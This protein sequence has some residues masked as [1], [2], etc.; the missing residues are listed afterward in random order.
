MWL[1]CFFFVAKKRNMLCKY[2]LHIGALKVDTGSA[3]CMEVGG[4]IA[5]L[6]DLVV[7]FQRMDYGG[8]V[9]T[10]GSEIEFIDDAKEALIALWYESD[11]QSKAAFAVYVIN[12]RWVYEPLWECPLDFATFRYDDH[13]ATIGCVDTSAA[14]LI[15]ANRGTRYH[16]GAVGLSE[17]VKLDYDRITIGNSYKAQMMGTEVSGSDTYTLM[18]NDTNTDYYGLVLAL[19]RFEEQIGT[20]GSLVLNDEFNA[21]EFKQGSGTSGQYYFKAL[22]DCEVD[23]DF[24]QMKIWG[25]KN[26]KVYNYETR[27]YQTVSTSRLEL[28]YILRMFDE[29]D[30]VNTE[31]ILADSDLEKADGVHDYVYPC[32][33]KGKFHVPAGYSV[34]MF[35]YGKEYIEDDKPWIMR[36]PYTFGHDTV[37][38]LSTDKG[39]VKWDSRS[40]NVDMRVIKPVTLLNKLLERI[41][42]DKM[43]LRGVIDDEDDERLR[44]TV[45]LPAEEIRGFSGP[46]LYSSFKQFC[47]M[48]EAVFGYV[49]TIEDAEV[50]NTMKVDIIDFDEYY[51]SIPSGGVIVM[52]NLATVA[53]K[54]CYFAEAGRF[55]GVSV[56]N[57]TTYLFHLWRGCAEYI[58]YANRYAPLQKRVYFCL[59]TYVPY[60]YA[61]GSFS[62]FY[63]EDIDTRCYDMIRSFAEI[64]VGDVQDDRVYDGQVTG[65]DIVYVT[66]NG[67]FMCKDQGGHFYSSWDGSEDYNDGE[68]VRARTVFEAL[69]AQDT[70][71]V[72]YDGRY[73]LPCHEQDLQLDTMQDAAIVR[74]VHRRELFGSEVQELSP[75]ASPEVKVDSERLFSEIRIGYA[76]QEYDLGN[77]GNDEWNFTS[78]YTT[79][80]QLREKALELIC[81]YRADCYGIEELAGKRNMETSSTDSDSDLFLVK[82]QEPDVESG[83][84]TGKFLL[85]RSITVEGSYTDTVFN[86]TYAPY[87]CLQANTGY[88]GSFTR[89]VRF[90]SSDGNKDIAFRTGNVRVSMQ[91]SFVPAS[92]ERLF[93]RCDFVVKTSEQREPLAWNALVAFDWRSVQYQG[94]VKSVTF[95]PQHPEVVEYEL[96][97]KTP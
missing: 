92:N 4:M 60:Q 79:N 90:A 5:N 88:V 24:T 36:Q 2:Y 71:Y 89:V 8:V 34:C 69:D 58:D 31:E 68:H 26:V 41:G 37:L 23:I 46:T 84:W 28:I 17:K 78:V 52:G 49:Y 70:Y 91:A 96:I 93:G 45:L 1:L 10:C 21:S 14:A 95:N 33:I 87:F 81:P 56:V 80:S 66:G 77:S 13:R 32:G 64:Y 16:F 22:K 97:G 43:Q 75:I 57:G 44:N 19:S 3:D 50:E 20:Q 53:Q 59:Q 54:V 55:Y 40:F 62:F 25:T 9:R 38:Y 42:G 6:S 86:A 18:V 15:K 51:N 74:F 11:V 73:L 39:D 61:G 12:E 7:R 67:L 82:I 65:S 94:Y 85:D 27:T 29:D 48:M 76:K 63:L 47:E 35:V 83:S 30:M 72:C